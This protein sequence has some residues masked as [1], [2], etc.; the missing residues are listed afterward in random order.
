MIR[1][2][3][4]TELSILRVTTLSGRQHNVPGRHGT[5]EQCAPHV[6]RVS[7]PCTYS[8]GRLPTHTGL[9]CATLMLTRLI[10]AAPLCTEFINRLRLRAVEKP[11]TADDGGKSMW[12]VQHVLFKQRCVQTRSSLFCRRFE[13]CDLAP[14]ARNLLLAPSQVSVG[15]HCHALD[16]GRPSR[17]CGRTMPHLRRSWCW[18]TSSA[19]RRRRAPPPPSYRACSTSPTCTPQR[20]VEVPTT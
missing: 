7:S 3:Y 13:R 16:A 15:E 19:W 10:R 9:T 4:A 1:L 2:R 12:E 20:R 18:K 8:P 6:I 14:Q 11:A 5:A 17:N